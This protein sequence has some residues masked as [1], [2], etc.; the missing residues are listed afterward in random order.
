MGVT[1][2][3]AQ[4]VASQLWADYKNSGYSGKPE[5]KPSSWWREGSEGYCV[6]WEEGPDSW[7]VDWAHDVAGV[8]AEPYNSFV[9]FLYPED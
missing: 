9:L 6:Q 7:A 3:Q 5:V 8:F 1:K 2:K 4:Q